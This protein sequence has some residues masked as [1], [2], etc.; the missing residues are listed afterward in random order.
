MGFPFAGLGQ[1]LPSFGFFS[2]LFKIVVFQTVCYLGFWP[3]L[4]FYSILK[5]NFISFTELSI[6]F[7]PYCCLFFMVLHIMITL[8]IMLSYTEIK[9]AQIETC[10]HFLP[11]SKIPYEL[12]LKS[13]LIL[14]LDWCFLSEKED[15]VPATKNDIAW[16]KGREKKVLSH[17]SK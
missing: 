7:N 14:L 2:D 15:T 12:I 1:L 4:L 13:A 9:L 11:V 5:F 10:C 3:F 6:F 8:W 16:R 17:K